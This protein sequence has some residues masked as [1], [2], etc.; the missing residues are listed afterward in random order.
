MKIERCLS[1]NH[2]EV[3]SWENEKGRLLLTTGFADGSR[4]Y[5]MII[6]IKEISP[7]S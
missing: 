2:G 6:N 1:L 3:M 7:K 5:F 4:K